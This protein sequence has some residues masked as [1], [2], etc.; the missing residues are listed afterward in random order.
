M[1]LAVLP[2][3][4]VT[5]HVTVV[6]P[7]GNKYVAGLIVAPPTWAMTPDT[8]QLSPVVGVPSVAVVVQFP[9]PSDEVV[10][11]TGP[12]QLIVGFS[13]SVTVTVCV[14]LAVLPLPSVTIHVTVVDPIGNKYVAGLIVAPPTWAMTPDTLQL[15]PVVGVPSVAV[16]VQFPATV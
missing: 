9:V 8:L 12:K 6:D 16:V 15:S 11:T 5:I 14:Q 1:Q 4:S 10:V 13:L 7:I 3:P 2:L